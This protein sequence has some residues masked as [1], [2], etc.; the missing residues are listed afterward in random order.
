MSP[1]SLQL[2]HWKVDTTTPPPRAT[3]IHII[4]ENCSL[5]LVQGGTPLCSL[6]PLLGASPAMHLLD[7][8]KDASSCVLFRK[9]NPRR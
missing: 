6:T 2:E 7:E 1:P 9:A 3:H 4:Q 5:P 8:S